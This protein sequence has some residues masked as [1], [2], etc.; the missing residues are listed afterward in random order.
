[1]SREFLDHHVIFLITHVTIS[2]FSYEVI[3]L[4]TIS[5]FGHE[6]IDLLTIT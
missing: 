2:Y 1:L 3:D 5:Y 4:L 6:V